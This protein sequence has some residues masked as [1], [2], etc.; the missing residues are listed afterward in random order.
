MKLPVLLSIPHSGSWIPPEVKGLCILSYREII[1]DSDNGAVEIYHPLKK[2]VQGFVTTPVARAI[3]DMNR[4]END[5]RKDGVVKTHTCW[6]LPVYASPLT[7]KLAQ[8]LIKKYH[9]PFHQ[10]LKEKAK[11]ARAGI[12]CHTM[13]VHGPPVGPDP[14]KKRPLACVSNGDGTC[15]NTLLKAFAEILGKKLGE[16]VAMNNPFKGG[17]I[18]RKRLGGIPWLQVEFSRVDKPDHEKKKEGF[19]QTLAEWLPL[20][21]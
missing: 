20:L 16:K 7:Q 18:I 15:S 10:D 8:I 13:A 14:G 19:Y 1:E 12:D 5:F 4:E 21:E 17:P 6:N 9:K 11:N 3:V 2:V